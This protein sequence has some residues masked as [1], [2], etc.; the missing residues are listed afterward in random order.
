MAD[1]EPVRPYSKEVSMTCAG[2]YTG[3][4][5]TCVLEI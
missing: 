5:Y 2:H 4:P 3:D 1:D